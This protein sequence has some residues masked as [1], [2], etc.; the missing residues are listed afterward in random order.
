MVQALS[1][2][3][4]SIQLGLS[5]ITLTQPPRPTLAGVLKR[6]LPKLTSVK[7]VWNV[8]EMGYSSLIDQGIES[9]HQLVTVQKIALEVT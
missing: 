5:H 7:L 2:L 9:L 8:W 4:S 1:A 3:P 6:L